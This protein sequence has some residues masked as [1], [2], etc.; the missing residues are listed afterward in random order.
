MSS[1]SRKRKGGSA[2]FETHAPVQRISADWSRPVNQAADLF[3]RI[4]EKSSGIELKETTDIRI[5]PRS[6]CCGTETAASGLLA[7]GRRAEKS[8]PL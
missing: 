8:I 7:G 4:D 5:G 2:Q 1:G 3:L 6:E